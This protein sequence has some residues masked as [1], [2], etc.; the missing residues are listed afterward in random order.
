MKYVSIDLE[1]TGL[2]PETCQIIEFGAVIDDTAN[3]KPLN[4][5][6]T[7][8]LYIDHMEHNTIRGEPFALSM[9][10]EIFRRIAERD[11]KKYNFCTE[12]AV[13]QYFYSFLKIILLVF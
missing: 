6:P 5:L 7:F 12:D 8:H 2:N 3:P 11:I 9:H 10:S 13:A 4:E 1:T